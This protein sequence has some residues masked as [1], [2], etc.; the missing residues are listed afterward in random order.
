[1]IAKIRRLFFAEHWKIGT[2]AS[3]LNLHPDTVRGAIESHRFNLQRLTRS[4]AALTD[5]YLDFINQ[6][7]QQYPR[8]RSTRIYEMLSAR[9]Y[10]GS[11]VQLRRVV[12]SLRPQKFECDLIKPVRSGKTIYVC[13]DGNDYSIPPEAVGRQLT[14]L[15]SPETVRLLDGQQEIARHLRSYSRH[16]MI[17]DPAHI[18]A[19]V[20]DKRKALGA[21]AISRLSSALPRVGEFL[22]AAFARGES[23]GRQSKKL[24]ELLDDYGAK[25]L[26]AAI[27]E[28]LERQT[29]HAASLSLILEQRRRKGSNLRLPVDLSHHPHLQHFEDLSV[30]TQGLEVYDEGSHDE[31]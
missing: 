17:E 13:F 22:D 30:P 5:P 11:V 25:E 19:V 18:A 29:P 12:R 9:G 23:L 3:E 1:M 15:A 14:L 28:S 7:L 31:E 6:T 21:T 24:I 10:A 4:R 16:E 2:I 27:S 8:L 20:K 26:N